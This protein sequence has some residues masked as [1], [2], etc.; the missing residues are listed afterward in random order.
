MREYHLRAKCCWCGK[1]FFRGKYKGAVT[2]FCETAECRQKQIDRALTIVKN[3]K[4]NCVYVPTPRQVVF[5]E[6]TEETCFV[7]VDGLNVKMSK[8][9]LYGG[10]AGGAKSHSIRWLFYKLC[11]STPDYHCLL[12]RRNL[13][14]LEDTH[15]KRVERECDQFGAVLNRTK[16]LLKF[17]NGSTIK[18]GHLDDPKDV[19]KFLSTEYEKIGFDEIVTFPKNES[20]LIMSRARTTKRGVFAGVIAGTNPG[21]PESYW[22]KRYWLDKDINP[23]EDPTYSPDNY[24]YIQ[25]KLD[26]NPHLG[27]DYEITLLRLPEVLRRAYRDGDWDIFPGQFFT[28]WRRDKHCIDLEHIPSGRWYLVIDWGY[29]AQGVALFVKM[30]PEGRAIVVREHL[31][32]MTVASDVAKQIREVASEMG[33]KNPHGIGDTDMHKPGTDTGES[34]METFARFNVPLVNADKDRENG[35][36]RLRHW[37]RDAPD[38]KPWLQVNEKWCPYLTRTIPSLVM[39][40]HYPED[41]ADKL[42]DHAAD[43]LRYFC[44]AQPAPDLE[45][46]V[47]DIPPDSPK[48][49]LMGEKRQIGRAPGQVW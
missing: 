14:E 20:L 15:I 12:L 48:G 45:R 4:A 21:G 19:E 42:E 3:G 49:L 24:T 44:M 32:R 39:D 37:L 25:A 6:A 43:A 11:L 5:E 46:E 40:D 29:M 17:P 8:T 38:G 2:W 1:R 36:Q 31:F 13:T 16:Y 33:W 22:V 10:A 18:F 34:P 26:D 41:I 9:V 27:P 28:E 47:V 35:W 23:E 7:R 30:T